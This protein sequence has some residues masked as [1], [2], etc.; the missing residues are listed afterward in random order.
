M[1][2][3]LYEKVDWAEVTG[4]AA[5]EF[6]LWDGV[7]DPLPQPGPP[8][9][10]LPHD[11]EIDSST[12]RPGEPYPG[13][14]EGVEYTSDSMG[15]VRDA[16]GHVIRT[17]K[18]LVE[19]IQEVKGGAGR[20]RVTPRAH[21]VLVRVPGPDEDW[22]TLYVTT[23]DGPLRPRRKRRRRHQETPADWA[24]SARV[25][26][27][28]PFED[29]GV[30]EELAFGRKRGG[31]IRRKVRGGEVYARVGDAAQD[32]RAGADAERLLAAWR[33]AAKAHPELTKF[34]INEHRH[35]VFREGGELRFLAAL[36]VGLEFPER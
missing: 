29:A 34:Q 25:G 16:A 23:L 1:E 11:D 19:Q 24:K 14:Y 9:R 35:A 32:P 26:D 10:P 18:G 36:E 17:P 21:H 30:V 6:F 22:T 13:R 20:F 28:Y 33:E 5:N 7:G 8:R 12:L 15:N 2:E 27:P 3:V 31:V 4:A